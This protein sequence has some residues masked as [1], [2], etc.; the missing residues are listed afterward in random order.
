MDSE[1]LDSHLDF[2][3]LGIAY[4]L[5]IIEDE[6]LALSP[7]LFPFP[8]SQ[9]SSFLFVDPGKLAPFLAVGT[10]QILPARPVLSL[11]CSG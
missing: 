9:Q 2:T 3:I 6:D 10:E 7:Y 4:S 11:D 5:P 1:D 8:F